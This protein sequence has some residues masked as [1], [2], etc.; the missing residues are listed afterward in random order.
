MI[1]S[2]EL[3]E[4]MQKEVVYFEN[5]FE[6]AVIQSNPNGDFYVKF[7]GHKPFKAKDGSKV[8]ADSIANTCLITK[9]QYDSF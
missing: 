5:A 3:Y 8:V 2:T 7:K 9:K 1:S 4:R 6:T